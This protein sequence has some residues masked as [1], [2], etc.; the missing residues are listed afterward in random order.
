MTGYGSAEYN[1]NGVILTVEIKT[2]NNRNFDLNCK[3]PRAFIMFEDK[4]RKTVSGYIGRGRIDLFLNFSDR[5]EKETDLFVNMDLAKGYY[6]AAKS[7]SETLGIESGL[8]SYSIM[9]LPDVIEN[10]NSVDVTEFETILISTV[11]KA[12]EELNAMR[13]AE[14]EKL[15]EDMVQRMGTIEELTEKIA[16]RA[17]L[18]AS[19]YKEKLTARISEALVKVEYDESKLMNEVAFFVDKANIDEEL[20]RLGSHV[21]QFLKICRIDGSGKKL[22]FLMQEFNRETNTICSKANDI[23]ITRLALDMKNEI[24][25]VREQVQNLE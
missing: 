10:N 17:P 14:G 16:V 4:I 12:C 11:K 21:A 6:N 5:R 13:K 7:I 1:E 2:V 8:T 18:V 20:T 25:K 22:D 19:D 24:E 3:I 9:K 23:E 15:V